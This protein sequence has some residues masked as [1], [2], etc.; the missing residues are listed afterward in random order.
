MDLYFISIVLVTV[1]LIVHL[2]NHK[3]A[4]W[5]LFGLVF[6]IVAYSIFSENGR[7]SKYKFPLKVL[8]DIFDF[9]IFFK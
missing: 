9:S 5:I 1:A 3:Q 2:F 4:S 6:V 7:S 8:N